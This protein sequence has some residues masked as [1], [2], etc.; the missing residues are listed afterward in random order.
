MEAAT[1]NPNISEALAAVGQYL[2][3]T[4]PPVQA[5]EP[6]VTL[7]AQPTQLMVS[8]IL[9]WIPAQFKGDNRNISYADYLFHAVTKL[10]YLMQLQLISE[11]ALAPY[12]DSVKL[13]LLDRCPPGDRRLLQENFGRLGMSDTVTATPIGLIY[14]QMKSGESESRIAEGASP[15]Q[16]R[17]RRF[18]M[19]RDRLQSAVRQAEDCPADESAEDLIPHMIATAA[20][21]ARSSE[22]F[23]RLQ[24]N[25]KSLGIASG[26]DH[27]YRTLSQSLPG[28]MIASTG[29]ETLKSHNPAVEAMSQIIHLAEDR[30]E[31]CKRFQDLVQAA[32]EQFNKGSYAR[33]ATMLDLALVI[34]SDEKVDP[35]A[36]MSIRKTAHESLDYNR[37]RAL[38]KDQDRQ[39]LLRKIL[40]FFDEFSAKNLLD[41]LKKEEKRDRRRL[42]LDLLETHGD[43]ARTLVLER[44]KELLASTNVAIDWHFARNLVCI[45]NRIPRTGDVP[46]GDEIDMVAP[47][48]R[49]SLPAPLIKE[50]L[51]FAGRTRCTQS[52]DLLISTADKLET[53]VADYAKSGR[54]A[55]QKLSLLDR[56][57]F[58]LAHYGTPKGYRR[59]VKHGLG[60]SEGMGDAVSRL[61][62]LSNQDLTNDK[63]SLAILIQFLKSQVPRKLLGMTIQKNEQPLIYTIRALSST[64]TPVVRQ[65]LERLSERFPETKIGQTAA[66]VLKE[67]EAADKPGIQMDRMLTGDLDLFGLPDLLQQLNLMQATGTLTLKDAKGY[68]AGTFLLVAGRMQDC[69]AGR[70]QGAEAAYQLL[71]K[72][73]LGTFVFQGQRNSG[74]PAPPEED[75]TSDLASV[76]AEGMRRYDE[77]QRTRAL[78]PD[79][80]RLK[81]KGP[82]P[83]PRHGQED[84]EIFDLI[85]Q[86]TAA[87]TSPEE[88]EAICPADA[89]RVR[90]VLARWI[91]EGILMVE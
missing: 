14:R 60:R 65:A 20:S 89:Y 81:R 5:V 86:K 23:R 27:I 36:V 42:L 55:T 2:S 88:C 71:E 9:E 43:A 13:L 64:H 21:D 63:E 33:A 62:Y 45:L 57:I 56:T 4:I 11:Q 72:P 10:H 15:G 73:I 44:L 51:S 12:L 91:E 19:L 50:A 24:E 66:G 70:L 22:E 85:Y 76:L 90:A 58:A 8:E 47:L 28:W 49:L 83:I 78:V 52:E 32:I 82:Q 6:V 29:K 59:V 3:D 25:L 40:S 30:W 79:F 53:V 41:S 35:S 74:A 77:L 61:A 34:S 69:N 16:S 87:G 1:V 17:E 75:K 18:S 7:L 84:A 54:D 37:L 68:P 67:F 31:G 26:T 39:T 48:L 38:I 80:C 46:A